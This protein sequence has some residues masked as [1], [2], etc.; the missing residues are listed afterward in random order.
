MTVRLTDPVGQ[1]EIAERLSITRQSL[2]N[3]RS[4]SRAGRTSRV[5]PFPAPDAVVSNTPLWSW[6]TIEPW[7]IATGRLSR[8]KPLERSMDL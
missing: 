7:A 5:H 4:E 1:Q 8:P 3:I 2:Y 6:S